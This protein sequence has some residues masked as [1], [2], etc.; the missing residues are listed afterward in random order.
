MRQK[1]FISLLWLPLCLAACAS[2]L[3][4]LPDDGQAKM[5]KLSSADMQNV[6]QQQKDR[7]DRAEPSVEEASKDKRGAAS[8]AASKVFA[9]PAPAIMGEDINSLQRAAGEKALIAMNQFRLANGA[10]PLRLDDRLSRLAQDHV[11]DLSIR[12]EVSSNSRNG[13]GIGVR[14]LNAGLTDIASGGSLVAGGY[15][16]I[17][18]A[19]AAWQQNEKRR[20]QLL[21]EEV[22]LLGFAVISDP[23]SP[24]GTYMEM[25]IAAPRGE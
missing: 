23:T 15:T 16:D 20:G 8:P 5:R 3:P 24:Y 22:S 6:A 7:K 21:N 18:N 12:K 14:L 4:L 13:Q 17:E 9:Q 25:I 11:M 1:S 2:P 10:P 19:L